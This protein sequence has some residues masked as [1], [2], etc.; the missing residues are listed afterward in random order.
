MSKVKL[1]PL[2]IIPDNPV[3]DAHA[4][5]W[6]AWMHSKGTTNPYDVDS[7][8]YASFSSGYNEAKNIY[9]D[10]RQAIQDVLSTR[11]TEIP[12]ADAFDCEEDYQEY[13][14]EHTIPSAKEKRSKGRPKGS[15]NKMKKSPKNIVV[16]TQITDDGPIE[17][18]MDLP[19]RGRPK[20]SK[21]KPKVKND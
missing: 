16:I 18:P 10:M 12:D 15:T 21:N 8:E 6:N 3:R 17:I 11:Y 2:R 1:Q 13:I 14:K 5:G 9:G 7:L 19:R 4:K 20:G